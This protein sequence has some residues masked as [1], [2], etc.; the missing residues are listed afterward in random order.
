M[1]VDALNNLSM[2]SVMILNFLNGIKLFFCLIN[3][4]VL[5]FRILKVKVD[6]QF[7]I[8]F[9]VFTVFCRRLSC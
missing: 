6:V 3:N 1:Y 9:N 5:I 2:I 7:G 8:M 4:G